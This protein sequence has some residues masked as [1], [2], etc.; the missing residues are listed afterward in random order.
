MHPSFIIH[1]PSPIAHYHDFICTTDDSSAPY[2]VRPPHSGEQ[3]PF[4][5][6]AL[7]ARHPAF[8]NLRAKYSRDSL[9]RELTFATPYPPIPLQ[10]PPHNPQNA[11]DPHFPSSMVTPSLTPLPPQKSQ[12]PSISSISSISSMVQIIIS[13]SHHLSISAPQVFT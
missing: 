3:A 9:Q 1:H 7:F 8:P 5:H 6:F 11:Y 4:A 13:P 2:S 12:N 10:T